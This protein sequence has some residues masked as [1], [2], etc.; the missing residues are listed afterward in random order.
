MVVG[1][2]IDHRR[3]VIW[4]YDV[5]VPPDFFE[6]VYAALLRW[7]RADEFEEGFE[8]R[9]NHIFAFLHCKDNTNFTLNQF[10]VQNNI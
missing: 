1:A 7:E 10:L 2:F 3:F 8:I 9:I 5:T 4:G 6:M